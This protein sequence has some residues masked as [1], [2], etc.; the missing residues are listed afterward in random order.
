LKMHNNDVTKQNHHVAELLELAGAAEISPTIKLQVASLRAADGF[1]FPRK[2]LA[3]EEG[4]LGRGGA[5]PSSRFRLGLYESHEDLK[6]LFQVWLVFFPS[7]AELERP[8]RI[9]S[10]ETNFR[11]SKQQQQL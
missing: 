7:R 10:S 6:A 9:R 3:N 11:K 1:T 4:R 2:E 5:A 8:P